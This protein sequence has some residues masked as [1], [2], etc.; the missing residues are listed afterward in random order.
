MYELGKT[1]KCFIVLFEV[2]L[3]L[4]DNG[5]SPEVTV[6][7]R[8]RRACIVF[9]GKILLQTNNLLIVYHPWSCP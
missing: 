4:Y 5:C 9:L 2:I 1:F 7:E 8:I 6:V 3:E